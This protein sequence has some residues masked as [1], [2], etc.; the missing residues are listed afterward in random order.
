MI[1]VVVQF[2]RKTYLLIYYINFISSKIDKIIMAENIH[3]AIIGS[4]GRKCGSKYFIDTLP[5]DCYDKMLALCKK[6]IK[7]IAGNK[8]ITLVSGGAAL[9]DHLAV[10][11]F[12]EKFISKL[13]LCLPCEW[14]HKNCQF[15]D[16]GVFNWK[17]NPGGTS[18]FYHKKFSNHFNMN[19]LKEIDIAI[20][21]GAIVDIEKGFFARN[22]QIACSEYLIAFTSS[23]SDIPNT[24]GTLSTWNKS[25]GKKIHIKIPVL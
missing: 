6:E 16:T 25:K 19:S 7:N 24:S 15:F 22:S 14:D 21:N 9:A 12:N 11:L 10:T 3:I 8:N 20:N 4:A 5:L 17:T 13:I 1:N 23:E 18:N 2:Y